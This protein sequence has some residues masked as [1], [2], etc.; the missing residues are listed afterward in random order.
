MFCRNN[1]K[2]SDYWLAKGCDRSCRTKLLC[3][4]VTTNY[5]DQS[6]CADIK[7]KLNAQHSEF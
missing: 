4:V 2:A 5:G 6:H 7:Q 1:H 3:Y